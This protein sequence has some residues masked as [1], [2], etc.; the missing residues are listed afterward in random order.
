MMR[1]GISA[2][3][4]VLARPRTLCLREFSLT[5][6][7]VFLGFDVKHLAPSCSISGYSLTPFLSGKQ[8]CKECAETR[9]ADSGMAKMWPRRSQ[10][11]VST[12]HPLRP[13]EE[14]CGKAAV[15]WACSRIHHRPE[16]DHHPALP[17]PQ[18][19][20]LRPLGQPMPLGDVHVPIAPG[21]PQTAPGLGQQGLQ[22]SGRYRPGFGPK[23]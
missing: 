6:Q 1:R 9:C 3:V 22:H 11:C 5:S 4:A 10:Q 18:D 13:V 19:L 20:Q 15:A 7:E 8:R 12:P 2:H 23:T 14:R 17:F 21:V 16:A